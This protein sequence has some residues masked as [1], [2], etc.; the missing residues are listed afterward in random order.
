M[1]LSCWTLG[2]QPVYLLVASQRRVVG[3]IGTGF[4]TLV[5]PL[6]QKRVLTPCKGWMLGDCPSWSALPATRLIID[7][8]IGRGSPPAAA[9]LTV[10]ASWLIALCYDSVRSAQGSICL[11]VPLSC[12]PWSNGAQAVVLAHLAAAALRAA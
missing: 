3:I 9:D 8:S 4:I 6:C 1:F 12:S 11:M 7:T 10:P 5:V 2:A